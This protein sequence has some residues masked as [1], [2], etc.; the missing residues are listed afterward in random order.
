MALFNADF[1]SFPST[2]EETSSSSDGGASPHLPDFEDAAAW[3]WNQEESHTAAGWNSFQDAEP[4]PDLGSKSGG[5]PDN[6]K[7][8]I[9]RVITDSE[10][11]EDTHRKCAIIMMNTKLV[12]E[13][14][15]RIPNLTTIQDGIDQGRQ[16]W[17]YTSN[18]RKDRSDGRRWIGDVLI[19]AHRDKSG[20]QGGAP[21][22]GIKFDSS[23]QVPQDL[24]RNFPN[25]IVNYGYNPFLGIRGRKYQLL[26]DKQAVVGIKD[27]EGSHG[28]DVARAP[29]VGYRIEASEAT[30]PAPSVEDIE[31]IWLEVS[32]GGGGGG[33]EKT[34]VTPRL[35][36]G[37][38]EGRFP[39][40]GGRKG[41]AAACSTE[42]SGVYPPG[43]E[44][45][46]SFD[47][48]PF[49]GNLGNLQGSD[50]ASDLR[51]TIH[52][53]LAAQSN[54][55][56]RRRKI[57]VIQDVLRQFESDD[58]SESGGEIS[59]GGGGGGGAEDMN[60]KRSRYRSLTPQRT[61]EMPLNAALEATSS[62]DIID[63]VLWLI[64]KALKDGTLSAEEKTRFE[65]CVC[66][67]ESRGLSQVVRG[68]Q[69]EEESEGESE[70]GEAEA[71]SV[72][73]SSY[74]ES[75]SLAGPSAE[76]DSWCAE[77]ESEKLANVV[78]ELDT[79]WSQRF[80]KIQKHISAVS[81]RAVST[82]EL[83]IHAASYGPGSWHDVT[84]G[85]RLA[86][87][88]G[89][90]RSPRGVHHIL[91]D[92]FP[93]VPKT[94][95]VVYSV[96]GETSAAAGQKVLFFSCA[97]GEAAS[98]GV[99]G[100]ELRIHG[101]SYGPSQW[102]DVTGKVILAVDDNKFSCP[103]GVRP[104]LIGGPPGQT[105]EERRAPNTFTV[106]YSFLEG[107]VLTAADVVIMVTCADGIDPN[108]CEHLPRNL[109]TLTLTQNRATVQAELRTAQRCTEGP[110]SRS[111]IPQKTPAQMAKAKVKKDIKE[112]EKDFKKIGKGIEN[113]FNLGKKKKKKNKS[114]I[115]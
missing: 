75:M 3:C 43:S 68:F 77:L 101:A 98:F 22:K 80:E 94:F 2:D 42:D 5:V 96:V 104:I 19:V 90:F 54:A 107:T 115:K 12:Q 31:G 71:E 110:P 25:V 49:W 9:T 91:G 40:R 4:P 45:A 114:R 47:D 15:R 20:P 28:I 64:L 74:D 38:N 106:F 76:I 72:L 57:E 113:L 56:V 93:G 69:S 36:E 63:E 52:E 102:H 66:Q 1:S 16:A 44:T 86:V 65:L 6:V 92:H 105:R 37:V 59:G 32:P 111:P 35:P 51:S 100:K 26:G 10:W 78:G 11:R 41:G 83:H 21:K 67:L 8:A 23:E 95:I 53:F 79:K 13:V 48:F 61:G 108:I 88:N 85:V 97:E 7:E 17:F 82:K 46:T 112:I 60:A 30:T 87:G 34:E 81:K 50:D 58:G 29:S 62:D 109:P 103:N 14:D 18:R 99:P 55:E 70:D 33:G 39:G 27:T 73:A 89:T 84:E 24:R